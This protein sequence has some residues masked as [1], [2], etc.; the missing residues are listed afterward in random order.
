MPAVLYIVVPCYNEQE[1]LP[2]TAP[3][4]LEKINALAAAGKI[5]GDSRVLFVNDGSKDKTWE[6]ISRLAAE[7]EHY[8]GISQSRNRGHQ[9]AVFA[10]L[11]EA[12]DRCDITISIDCDGQD[13]INAMDKMVDEYRNG[14]E[15]VYGVR[16]SRDTDTLFK[17]ATAQGFYKFLSAMGAEV[18]YNHADYRL[19]SA[20][21]LQELADF[22]EVNLFLRGMIPLVGFKS[23]CVGYAR[24]ER[25]A[26]KSHY[27]LKK[28]LA[29]AVDGITSLSVKPL[30]LITGFGVLV[31]LAS[32]IGVIWALVTALCGKAVAGWASTTC[33]VC[34]VSGV[35][36]ICLGILGEYVG[37]IY[38]ETKQRPRYIIS[39]RTWDEKKE[40]KE[41]SP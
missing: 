41:K 37:K 15:V 26:G 14:C 22:K 12:K 11:M 21:V 8:L 35:Q 16:E 18:I 34:F 33:I 38:M 30:H 29:L 25:I 39:Q 9:N 31:A 36:L 23:T 24:A 27:P 17:R 32:F 28:M 10:G 19:I 13:D 1:V 7:D 2:I 4:F 6:I 5:S 20:R 40:R 3:M